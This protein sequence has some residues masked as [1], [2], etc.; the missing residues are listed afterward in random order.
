MIP[1]DKSF[2]RKTERELYSV[3]GIT[4]QPRS[5][6][7]RKNNEVPD[8]WQ[9]DE[10]AHTFT[11]SVS[12]K[13]KK[14]TSMFKKIF[15]ASLVFLVMTIIVVGISSLSGTN[16][17]SGDKIDMTITA[18]TFVDGGETL[19]VAISLVNRNNVNLELATLVL[20]YPEGNANNPNALVRI[21][22]DIGTVPSG[23]THNENFSIKLYGEENSEKQLTARLEFR[24]T[25]SNIVYDTEQDAAV[26]IRTSPIRLTLDAPATAIPNQE[27]PLKFSIIGNGTELLKN[28][29]LVLEYPPGF[30]FTRAVPVP[31]TDTTVW[32]LGDINPGANKIITVYGTFTGGVNDAKTI[33]ASVG[34]QNT[35][36]ERLLDTTY[37]SIAQVIPLSNAF[38]DAK[39]V[40]SGSDG[41]DTV[42]IT[43]GQTVNVSIPWQN[44]L[45]STL[46]NAQVE[47]VFGGSGYDPAR[48]QP[49]SG[50]FDSLNNKIIWTSQQVSQFAAIDPGA[51]GMLSFTVQPKQFTSGQIASSPIITMTVNITGFDGSGTKQVATNI[52]SKTLAVGSDINFSARTIYYSGPFKNEGPMPLVPN[53]ET[54]YTME[55]RMTNSRNRVTGVKVS[56]LLP[57][58]VVWKGVV[59]PSSEQGAITY[60][61][62]TRELVW[63][64]GEVQAGTGTQLPARSVF[65]KVGIIP[66]LSQK[67]TTPKLT[68]TLTVTGFDTFTKKT[69]E[70]TRR[71][72]DT[73]LSNDGQGAGF[74]GI[75]Q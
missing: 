26:T 21:T 27:L 36:N 34:S 45:A 58:Y 14:T 22:R 32:Y 31:T 66:S 28:T 44:T 20:E 8:A 56:T 75:V 10:A 64:T 63:N 2:L 60:N 33:R 15:M 40:V 59:S 48:V 3:D 54:T 52:D 17:I 55:W 49:S 69:I 47:V 57:N 6:L 74:D 70:I 65:I 43:S 1:D 12:M 42:A 51:S 18:K 46:T 71:A 4:S 38:L 16:A 13:S 41:S 29:A 5:L 53:K 62:I 19:P 9:E 67:G 7:H 24:V 50:F 35:K 37:N 72:L 25:G 11:P 23:D 61:E 68:D 73:Q 30:T 39:L